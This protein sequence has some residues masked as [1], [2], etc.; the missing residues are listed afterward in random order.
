[1]SG[2]CTHSIILFFGGEGGEGIG[3]V[4]FRAIQVGPKAISRPFEMLSVG[5]N[6]E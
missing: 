1:M 6:W 3:G 4:H 2:H 5:L